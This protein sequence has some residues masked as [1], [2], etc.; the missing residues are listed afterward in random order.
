MTVNIF[1]WTGFI[2]FSNSLFNEVSIRQ[3]VYIKNEC[4]FRSYIAY[5]KVEIFVKCEMNLK[6][7]DVNSFK[8]S[9]LTNEV[10]TSEVWDSWSFVSKKSPPG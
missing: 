8:L 7:K 5:S 3:I 4:N 2:K 6:S 9:Y 1:I 10:D